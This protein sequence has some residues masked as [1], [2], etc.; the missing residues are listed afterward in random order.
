MKASYLFVSFVRQRVAI[1]GPPFLLGACTV[2]AAFIVALFI[3]ER[4]TADAK[5]CQELKR[6]GS[7]TGVH[8]NTP[9]PGSD[10]DFEPL[11]EDSTV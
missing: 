1:P 9:L 6:S 4:P 8:S 5:T 2:L 10:E 11:L 3:P 7:L